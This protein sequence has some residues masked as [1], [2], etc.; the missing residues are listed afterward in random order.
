MPRKLTQS[1]FIDKCRAV[2]GTRYGYDS[3]RYSTFHTPIKIWCSV[4]GEFTQEPESHLRG[5]GCP[6][7]AGICS[8]SNDEFIQRASTIHLNKFDYSKTEFINTKSKITIIC[9]V[10]GEFEQLAKSHLN[11]AGCLMCKH[12]KQRMGRTEFISR[13]N[14]IHRGRYDYSMVS[15]ID[16][17]TKVSIQ[18]PIHGKFYQQP[19][20]HL[21]GAGC[22][23]CSKWVSLVELDFLDTIGIPNTPSNRQYRIGRYFVDGIVDNNIYEFLGDYWHGNPSIYNQ[24][25]VNR[26][27]NRTFGDL[28]QKTNDKF[29]WLASSGFIVNYIWETD[30]KNWK[31]DQTQQ[32]PIQ[33][34][35]TKN[36]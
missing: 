19:R 21:K 4:H 18:C 13:A 6:Q 28:Y 33:I 7:C 15:Y 1:E 2:H 26:Q 20:T 17:S 25:D 16:N 27:V 30:W 11:G 12:E 36:S 29:S 31:N 9:P 34:Y 10:H 24:S 3:V 35:T 22:P 5:C 14:H 32:I 8:M 23:Y